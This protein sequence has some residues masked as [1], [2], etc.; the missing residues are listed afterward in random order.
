MSNLTPRE[1]AVKQQ[2]LADAMAMAERIKADTTTSAASKKSM[3]DALFSSKSYSVKKSYAGCY[4]ETGKMLFLKKLYF[5][6]H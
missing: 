4:T 3:L 5:S 2:I 1:I 6:S